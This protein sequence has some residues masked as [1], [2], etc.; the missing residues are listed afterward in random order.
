MVCIE[1]K[2]MI[3]NV[4][5]VEYELFYA[6]AVAALER[7]ERYWLTHE[8]EQVQMRANEEFRQRPLYE[9]L[10][11]RFYRPASNKE[12]GVKMSAGEIYLSIQQASGLKLPQG[13]VAHFG[14]FP[15][16]MDLPVS[17]SSRGRLYWVVKREK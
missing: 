5:P 10:F 7:G 11:Y 17:V 1:V 13:Q 4:Q 14:R 6:Q 8:E 9:D 3:D 16:R 2:G 15:K 12:E